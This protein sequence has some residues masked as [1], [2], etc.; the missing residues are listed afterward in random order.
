MITAPQ[1]WLSLLTLTALEIVLSVDNLVVISVLVGKLTPELQ[2]KA[3]F[4]GM[5][6][7]LVPRLVLLLVIGWIIGLTEPLFEIFGHGFS[8]KDIILAGGGVFLIYKATQEIHSSLEGEEG[9]VGATVRAGF[10][11]V[12]SQ[13]ALI[14]LVFSIDSIVTAVG[15][16]N[17]IWVM[18]VAVIA[19]MVVLIAAAGPVGKFVDR[20]PTVKM[21]ALGFLI[22][23]GM[24]LVAD[25]FG[26]HIPKGYVYSAMIFSVLVEGVNMLHR[27]KAKPVHLHNQYGPEVAPAASGGDARSGLVSRRSEQTNLA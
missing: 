1:I 2:P 15:M 22:M 18:V 23:I 5:A 17:E 26:V 4:L 6:L 7:A 11:A 21:L 9:H 19:S 10:T 27:R 24:T 13:I 16:A 8:G 3:R 12:V 20:H 25:G 14:N